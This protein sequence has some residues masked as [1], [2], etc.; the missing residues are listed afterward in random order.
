MVSE[1]GGGGGGGR[2][3]GRHAALIKFRDFHMAGGEH[4]FQYVFAREY[5]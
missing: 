3:D 1:G 4:M 2:G 5:R